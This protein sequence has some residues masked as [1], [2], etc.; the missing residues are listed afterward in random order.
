VSLDD[1][2][3]APTLAATLYRGTAIFL[4][5]YVAGS[6]ISFGVHL[7]IAR[8]L[9]TTSYGYFVY[10][11][12]WMAIVLLCCNVGLKPTAVRFV[13]AYRAR[14]EWGLLKGFLRSSTSWTIAASVVAAI[15]STIALWLLRPRL[16]EL[17]VTLLLLATAMPFMALGEVW[18]SAVR[19]LGGRAR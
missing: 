15:L 1:R 17:G 5:I 13:A 4:A 18:S 11:T 12:S 19:G 8:V 16:D 3:R 10:G 6:A 14:G 7:F 9:G 2:S